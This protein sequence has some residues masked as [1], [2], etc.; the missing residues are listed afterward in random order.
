MKNVN[1]AFSGGNSKGLAY[2]RVVKE[3][4]LRGGYQ[5]GRV[6]GSSIGGVV[7]AAVA[8]QYSEP[9]LAVALSKFPGSHIMQWNIKT[10]NGNF[11]YA[12][13][14]IIGAYNLTDKL[15]DFYKHYFNWKM[16]PKDVEL[17]VSFAIQEELAFYS[18]SGKHLSFL[19]YYHMFTND[20][21]M[22]KIAKSVNV[23]Y[24]GK[25]GIYYYSKSKRMLYK[26]T[27]DVIPLDELVFLTMCNPLFKDRKVNMLG[28]MNTGFDGGIA[29]NTSATGQVAPYIQIN[30]FGK[31]EDK[32]EN[33]LTNYYNSLCPRPIS[34][35]YLKP[36]RTGKAFFEF[37]HK[38]IREEDAV[39][40]TN[41]LG[42]L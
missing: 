19:D 31:E 36:V 6:T 39:P 17:Y 4:D 38:A 27:D 25:D 22:P 10:E 41:I 32:K 37:T 23:Y 12:I 21:N 34:T 20:G 16:V 11:L 7:G 5:S 13:P 9:Q 30:C 2:L 26:M 33:N 24:G 1:L 8:C 28:H 14:T 18:G 40:A 35:H 29:D 3:I 42:L 15:A